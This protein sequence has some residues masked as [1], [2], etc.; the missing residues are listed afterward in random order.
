MMPFKSLQIF[1]IFVFV[2]FL[3]IPAVM[4]VTSSAERALIYGSDSSHSDRHSLA[5]G[6]EMMTRQT[7]KSNPMLLI[8]ATT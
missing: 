7:G 6:K 2:Y 3:V 1:F 5:R 8:S 4:L